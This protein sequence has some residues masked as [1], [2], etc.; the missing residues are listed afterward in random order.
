MK[1]LAKDS[2]RILESLHSAIAE[3]CERENV[4][5][6][7]VEVRGSKERRIVEIYLDKPEG[8]SL[9]ECA[10]FSERIGAMI[11]ERGIFPAAYRL[12]VSS[13]GVERPLLYAWQYARNIG[14]LVVAELQDGSVVKGRIASVEGETV[15]VRRSSSSEKKKARSP[16]RPLEA[17]SLSA[18]E[19]NVPIAVPLSVIKRGVIQLEF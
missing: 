2:A 7:A 4:V 5:A 13:P 11:E 6:I 9:D 15:M 3:L 17:S 16:E 18:A 14:R 1:D 10:V 19:A 8:I 12:D